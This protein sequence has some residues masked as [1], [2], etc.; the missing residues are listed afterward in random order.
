MTFGQQPQ[1]GIGRIALVSQGKNWFTGELF[2][3]AIRP[4][5]ALNT[6]NAAATSRRRATL[7]IAASQKRFFV[8]PITAKGSPSGP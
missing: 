8:M 4:A 1:T 5:L 2:R 6:V 7:A 3:S